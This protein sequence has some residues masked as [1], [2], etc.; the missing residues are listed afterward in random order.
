MSESSDLPSAKRAKVSSPVYETP[1]DVLIR[2]D[3]ET[4]QTVAS[5]VSERQAASLTSSH[6]G[7]EVRV[8]KDPFMCCVFK[9]LFNSDFLVKA[10]VC[11]KEKG[12]LDLGKKGLLWK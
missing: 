8:I 6:S 11:G 5:A 2:L 10:K 1:D 12:G 3:E 4:I 7:H 9:K